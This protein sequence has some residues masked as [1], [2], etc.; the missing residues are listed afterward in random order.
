[1][2]RAGSKSCLVVTLAGLLTAVC[3]VTAAEVPPRSEGGQTLI[4]PQEHL[5]LGE[6]YHVTPGTGTQL[7]WSNDAPLMR[8]VATCNRV[9]GYMVTPFDIEEGQP[10]LLAGTLRIPVASLSTGSERADRQSHGKSGLNAAEYPEITF[11]IIRVSDV[12]LVDDEDRQKSYTLNVAAELTIKDKT[13]ELE[14]PMRLT[15][16]PFTWQTARIN[17]GDLLI[18]RGR[19]DVSRAELG[20]PEQAKADLL[21]PTIGFDLFLFCSTMSPERNFYP[22]I[23]H[24]H[25]RKQLRFLTL[26]RDFNDPEQGYEFGR[27]YMREI[28]DDAPALGRLA[29]ATLSE[30][31]IK[32]RDLGFALKAAQ[33]A[34]QLTEFKDAALLDTLARVYYDKAELETAL[35]WARQAVEHIG[36]A[37]PPVAARVRATLQRC[38][39]R[40]ERDRE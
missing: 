4:V 28:W 35:K 7:V 39:A 14:V 19:V 16:I 32:T 26:L 30:E 27:G 23:K 6:V 25:H 40:A 36:D 11:R 33:R 8:I 9:V 29:D 22:D 17:M 1:M 13:V 12:K 15:L 38:E 37:A 10:P 5:E 2:I 34:N 20:Q 31:G 24:E 18:L 21:A 3:G